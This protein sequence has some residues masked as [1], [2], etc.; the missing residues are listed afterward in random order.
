MAE[1]NFLRKY[2]SALDNQYILILTSNS[3]EKQAVNNALSLKVRCSIERDTLGCKLGLV[4]GRFVLHVTGESGV[5]GSKSISRIAIEMLSRGDL[6]KPSAV[7]LVGFCWGNPNLVSVNQVIVSASVYSLNKQRATPQGQ[8]FNEQCIQSD[9]SSQQELQTVLPRLLSAKGIQIIF[10]PLASMETRLED[11]SYRNKILEKYPSILGGEMEAFGFLPSCKQPWLVIKAIS[12]LGGDEFNSTEQE[13]SA[14]RA[15]SILLPFLRL[16][17]DMSLLPESK[18]DRSADLLKDL[19]GGDAV[20]ISEDD[21]T[22]ESL[23]DYLNNICGPSIVC[24]LNRYSSDKEYG[25][26]FSPD[27]TDLLLELMQNSLRHGKATY[28]SVRISG[29]TIKYEDDGNTFDLVKINGSHGGANAFSYVRDKYLNR[30]VELKITNNQNG[31]GNI[32]WFKLLKVEKAIA[33]ARVDC[34][35]IVNENTIG[36]T[37]GNKNILEFDASCNELYLDLTQILMTSRRLTLFGELKHAIS[38][39]KSV[40]IACRS[41]NDVERYS[42]E[43]KNMLDNDGFERISVFV[44]AQ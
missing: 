8:F 23:N 26:Q 29:D 15:A 44:T 1:D 40:F 20:A 32:Y 33:K 7:L 37:L 12:D 35:I 21:V 18:M 25:T 43:L 9:F 16:A 17:N 38:A 31:L 19:L 28:A 27:F 14:E 11:D 13:E 24:K 39:G 5:S 4:E 30:G 36:R 3:V 22:D 6:P 41:T 42:E 10:G 2:R 34:P